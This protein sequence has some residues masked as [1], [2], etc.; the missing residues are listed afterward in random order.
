M[1]PGSWIITISQQFMFYL[2]LLPSGHNELLTS[3]L[4]LKEKVIMHKMA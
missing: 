2:N 4:K 1:H 3:L